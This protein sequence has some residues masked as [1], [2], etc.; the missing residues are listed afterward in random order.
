M[1]ERKLLQNM[2]TLLPHPPW[3]PHNKNKTENGHFNGLV[4]LLLDSAP[5]MGASATL[6]YSYHKNNKQGLQYNAGISH[7]VDC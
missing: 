6:L 1:H 2:D 4:E 7:P 3:T 5:C